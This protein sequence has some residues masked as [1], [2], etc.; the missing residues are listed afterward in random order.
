MI[1]W[2]P[3]I[4]SEFFT[5]NWPVADILLTTDTDIPKFVYR[6][7]CRYFAKYF[8]KLV[9]IAYTSLV[10]FSSNI[11]QYKCVYVIAKITQQYCIGKIWKKLLNKF[12]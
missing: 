5:D 4:F 2:N 1:F 3:P 10:H 11:N 12:Q 6:Y 9:G 7:I 8:G